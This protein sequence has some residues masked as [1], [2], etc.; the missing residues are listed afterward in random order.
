M[1][2]LYIDNITLAKKCI[3]NNMQRSELH[4]KIIF[5]SQADKYFFKRPEVN[6]YLN[7]Q[8]KD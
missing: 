3:L 4:I 6:K 1:Y 2:T 7:F 5:Q 8:N